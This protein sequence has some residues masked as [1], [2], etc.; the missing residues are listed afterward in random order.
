MLIKKTTFDFGIRLYT[1]KFSIQETKTIA[2][3]SFKLMNL[4]YYAISQLD[5]YLKEF[6]RAPR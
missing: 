1:G 2:G 3:K 4:P 6:A 5:H